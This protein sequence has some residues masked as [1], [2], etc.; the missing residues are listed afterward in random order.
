MHYSTTPYIFVLIH[1]DILCIH[2]SINLS[3]LNV[4]FAKQQNSPYCIETIL[5]IIDNSLSNSLF[6]LIIF[7]FYFY[8]SLS[9]PV[10]LSFLLYLFLSLC[11]FLIN[12]FNFSSSF[13]LYISLVIC[14]S[15]FLL[16][17][18]LRPKIELDSKLLN[19]NF[20]RSIEYEHIS[21]SLASKYT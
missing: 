8:V 7:H 9:L 10:S 6:F 19:C 18:T 21:L 11:P 12:Y 15:T 4:P 13:F 14:L 5:F 2:Q 17:S 3:V 16:F 1:L 20:K